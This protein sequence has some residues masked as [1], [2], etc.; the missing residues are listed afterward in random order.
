MNLSILSVFIYPVNYLCQSYGI[1][2][3]TDYKSIVSLYLI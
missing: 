2:F 1:D 3:L